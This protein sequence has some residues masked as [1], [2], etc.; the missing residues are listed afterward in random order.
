MATEA[1]TAPRTKV[2]DFIMAVGK[3]EEDAVQEE[4]HRW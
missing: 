3:E 4:E 2:A 1:K